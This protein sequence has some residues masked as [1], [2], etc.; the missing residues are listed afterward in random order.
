[1]TAVHLLGIPHPTGSPLYVMLGKLWTV[2][3]P[4]GSI[5]WRMSLFSAVCSA[6]A[7][8]L[9]YRLCREAGLRPL[10]GAF[11]ALT[12]A[13]SPSFWG[14]ATVQRVYG[15]GALFVVLASI[16]AWRWHR[17]RDASLLWAFCICGVG[18]TV[19]VSLATYAVALACFAVVEEPALLRRGRTLAA[20]GGAFL[21]GALPYLY[22]PL[23]AR[24]EPRLNW[25]DPDD[26]QGV[27][28]VVLRRDFWQRRWYE[29]PA[30]LAVIAA[31][32]V[33]SLGAELAWVGAALAVVGVL[34]GW[35]RGWPVRLP[36]FVMA[37][38]LAALAVHGSRSDLFIWH[39]YYIPS[40]VMA[41][42]LAGIGCHVVLERV[43]RQLG[44]LVL[45]VPLVLLVRGWPQF[46]RSHYRIAEDFSLGLLRSLPPGAHLAATDDNVLFAL[47]YLH[48]VEQHRP[49]VDLILQGVGGARL[50]PLRFD[51]ES[52][53]LYFTHHPNWENPALDVVPMGLAF[54]AWRRGLPPPEPVVP[55]VELAGEHDPRV[56]KDYLTRNLIGHFHYMLGVTFETRDWPRAR[57]EFA[58]AAEAAPQNDVLFYNLGLIYRRNGLLDDA[59]AAFERSHAI[60]PRHLASAARPRAADR[61]AEVRAERARIAG[62]EAEL[63]QSADLADLAPASAA[64][65]GRLAALLA[66]RGETAAARAHRLRALDGA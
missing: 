35:R 40:Y 2:V 43:P 56:P 36:L 27:L 15:P 10:A 63:A 45:V 24:M 47:M 37:V 39:R 3:L 57:H 30:D 52:E 18:A 22:L 58:R 29:T 21:L 13:F 19:H 5:A 4:F 1:V 42:L 66:A 41:A 60:N 8:G 31:D 44:M 59:L 6:L 65:H 61:V 46:D 55:R 25:G 23:R 16:A 50:P 64:W 38:N 17:R 33:R 51:P 28:D 14:E 53:P 12:L 34:A 9:L 7:C 20:A 11:A 48:L 62:L 54:R 49:D 32:Y 26:V